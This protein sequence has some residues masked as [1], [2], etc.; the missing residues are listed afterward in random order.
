MNCKTEKLLNELEQAN[1][2]NFLD[3]VKEELSRSS[4]RTAACP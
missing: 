2:G 1:S 3:D 4:W